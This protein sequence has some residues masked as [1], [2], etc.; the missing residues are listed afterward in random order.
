MP[1]SPKPFI[2]P[3]HLSSRRS[4]VAGALTQRKHDDNSP[5]SAEAESLYPFSGT[6]SFYTAL[7]HQLRASTEKRTTLSRPVPPQTKAGLL[8][9]FHHAMATQDLDHIWP[10]YSII[11]ENNFIHHLSRRTFRHLFHYTVRSRATLANFRRLQALLDDMRTRGIELRPTEY[12]AILHW[13]GGRAVP[14]KR[15]YHLNDALK[16]FDEM[17]ASGTPPTVDAYNTLIYIASQRNDIPTAQRLYHDMV[18]QSIPPDAYTYATLITTMGRVGDVSSLERMLD[19]VKTFQHVASNVVVWN[20][21]MGGFA[22]S[23]HAD[24]AMAIF[25]EMHEVLRWQKW[26]GRRRSEEMTEVTPTGEESSKAQQERLHAERQEPQFPVP[27]ADVVSFQIHMGCLLDLNRIEDAMELLMNLNSYGVR[28]TVTMYNTL[29]A[30]VGQ[31]YRR[32]KDADNTDLS[33]IRSLYKS[34]IDLAVP[35]NS[36]TMDTL[37]NTLLDMGDTSFALQAFV[38]LSKDDSATAKPAPQ[39]VSG[40]AVAFLAPLRHTLRRYKSLPGRP[41]PS[42]EL[43]DRLS[44]VVG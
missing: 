21:A 25:D 23:G 41:K 43:L 10:L 4:D 15:P 27:A 38:Q 3:F 42:Q 37:I 13:V 22:A 30:A 44:Q 33:C 32:K 20:A 19:Q 2:R 8:S 6:Q 16:V 7:D 1:V 26:P 18:A 5:L 35:A 40:Q 29:F 11:Y 14:A 31:R 17:R 9:Q 34:M 12:H 39:N 24:R 36:N 28:P